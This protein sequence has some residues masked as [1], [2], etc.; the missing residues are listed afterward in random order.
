MRLSPTRRQFLSS[1]EIKSVNLAEVRR[2]TDEYARELLATHPEVEEVIVFGSFVE[3][4]YA[5][6]SDLDV[7]I[8]LQKADEPPRER[9]ARFLPTQFP[10]P[11]DPFPFTRAEMAEL[12]ESPLLVAV[13]KSNWRYRR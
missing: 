2:R 9:I 12:R 5:P 6:G 7:F 13:K 3:G 1:V 11:V 4:N 10:V 8:V